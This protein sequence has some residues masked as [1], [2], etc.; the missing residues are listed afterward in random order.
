MYF[1]RVNN[2]IDDFQTDA[3]TE[4]QQLSYILV[5]TVLTVL[6]ADPI[7]TSALGPSELNA[8]DQL[9]LLT[10]ILVAI[11]G[12]V[13]CY[14]TSQIRPERNGFMP[15]FYCLSLPVLVRVCVYILIFVL[16]ILLVNDYVILVPGFDN[17]LESETTTWGGVIAVLGLEIAFF[18][19]LNEAIRRSY[20]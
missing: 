8:L 4:R 15:R 3:V 5:W 7:V 2:L 20:A 13:V 17:Y 1:W 10:T 19:Y 18:S 16:L 9:L 11:T 6:S 12:T 14:R